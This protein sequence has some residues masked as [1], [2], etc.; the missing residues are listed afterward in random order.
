[1]DDHYHQPIWPMIQ[2]AANYAWNMIEEAWMMIWKPTATP[3]DR[4]VSD[5]PENICKIKSEM[6]D[7]DNNFLATNDSKGNEIIT[8]VTQEG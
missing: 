2:G 6:Q 5:E 7:V 4:T 3:Q 1:M 8:V